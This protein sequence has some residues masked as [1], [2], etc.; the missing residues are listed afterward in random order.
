ML[1]E[2]NS[3]TMA[4]TIKVRVVKPSDDSYQLKRH[5]IGPDTTLE[6]FKHIIRLVE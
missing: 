2:G 4:F 6:E 1:Y 5:G 3:F